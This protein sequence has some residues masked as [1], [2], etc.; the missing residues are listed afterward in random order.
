MK[1]KNVIS[2]ATLTTSILLAK[3]VDVKIISSSDVHGRIIPWEYSGD[4]Y[5]SGSFSQI[6]TYVSK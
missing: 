3:E 5:V 1:L 4:S 2:L 6:D